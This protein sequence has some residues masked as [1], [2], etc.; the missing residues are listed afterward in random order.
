MSSSPANK[1]TDSPSTASP[2]DVPNQSS[3]NMTNW[4]GISTQCH[5][6]DE[7]VTRATIW[8][9]LKMLWRMKEASHKR[10]HLI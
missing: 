10:P 1:G 6:K 2:S 7:V 5:K 3:F 4:D 8:M 9:D